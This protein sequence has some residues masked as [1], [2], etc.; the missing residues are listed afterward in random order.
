MRTLLILVLTVLTACSGDILVSLAMKR[1][2]EVTHFSPRA[3]LGAGAR[4]ARIPLFWVGLSLLTFS[5]YSFLALLSWAPVSFVVPATAL[6][7]VVGTLSARFILREKLGAARWMGVLLACVGVVLVSADHV[8]WVLTP[9]TLMNVIRGIVMVVACVPFMYY[10]TCAYAAR[11][12]FGT[13]R[14]K[15]PIASDFAPPVSILKPVRG[16]DREAYKNYSSFCRLD[17][18]E[19]EIVFVAHDETDTAIPVIKQVMADYPNCQ[20][21][22][23][24]GAEDLGT[25]NK[26]NKMIRLVR[27]SRYDLIAFSDSDVRVDADYLRFVVEPFRDPRVGAITCLF[28]GIHDG[29]L[30]SKLD[31]LGAAVEFCGGALISNEFEGTQF[32][33]GATMATTKQ[34]LEK[35]GGFEPLA[36]HHADDF[37]FGNRIF[38]LGLRVELARKPVWM[39][40]GPETLR[41]YLRHELRWDIGLRHIRPGGHFG[42]LFTQGLPFALLGAAIAPS[43]TI[44][45]AYVLAYFLLRFLDAWVV[46]VWGLRDPVVR[47]KFW[48]LPIRDFFAFPIWLASFFTNRIQWRGVE[49]TI[50]EGRM[51]RVDRPVPDRG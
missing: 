15:G 16:F 44:S 38:A 21:R 6:G 40:Y 27:E 34:T 47:R 49:F 25:N 23:L 5:F 46:G 3:L 39:I 35:I 14:S 2:G 4:L 42:L 50:R 32:A 45:V 30:A 26:V 1:V 12:F 28:R 8:G 41:Q 31:C 18:P 11:K 7:Y 20:I 22:L 33:H 51:I 37:E 10:L 48:L 36:D 24:I 9:Q 17:Y 43:Y 29:S 13:Q 19:Y